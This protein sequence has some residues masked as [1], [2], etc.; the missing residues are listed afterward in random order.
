[1]DHACSIGV[2]NQ[3]EERKRMTRAKVDA[4]AQLELVK[5]GTVWAWHE[6][7]PCLG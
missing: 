4:K 6:K 2:R 1:M 5:S 3:S 7:K